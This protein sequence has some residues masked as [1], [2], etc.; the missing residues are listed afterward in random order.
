MS[1]MGAHVPAKDIG[2]FVEICKI[3][4]NVEL[5]LGETME[6]EIYQDVFFC[7]LFSI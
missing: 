7:Y 4:F 6:Y 1:N 3:V 2:R 5:G